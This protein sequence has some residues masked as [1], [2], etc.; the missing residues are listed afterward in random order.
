[1]PITKVQNV[2][3]IS[4]RGDGVCW[5][6]SAIM[7]YRWAQATGKTGMK[8]P[9]SDTGTK[10]RWDNNK[11]WASGDNQ[12]LATTLNMKTLA[13]VPR[14]YAGLNDL[15]QKRGPIW[16]AGQKTWGGGNHGHV[17]V[18]CGAADTGAFIFDPEPVNQGS[19]WWLTWD[20]LEKYIAGSSAAVQF[21]TAV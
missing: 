18:I 7:L 8:D 1:M 13:S 9:L 14:D 17:V 2:P 6:A 3:L 19:S 15:L 12:F 21:L 11:D 5:C 10:W 4:Q 20:Q 16:C